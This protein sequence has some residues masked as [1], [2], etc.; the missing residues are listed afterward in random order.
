MSL[1]DKKGDEGIYT[2]IVWMM[3]EDMGGIIRDYGNTV[4]K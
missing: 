2:A 1:S 3:V 4:I